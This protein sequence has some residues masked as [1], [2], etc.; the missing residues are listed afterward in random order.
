MRIGINAIFR[1]KPTGVANYICNLVYNLSR[2]DREN[3]YYIFIN[4]A[5]RRYFP[6]E[7]ENFMLISCNMYSEMPAYRRLW[8]Q[9]AFPGY[10]KKYGLDL[11]HCP[12][13]VLPIMAKCK[14]VLTLIDTQYFQN[15]DHFSFLRRE[16]L[17]T[18]MKMSFEKS[19]GVITI[20]EEVKKEIHDIFDKSR[21][22]VK[23]IHLGMSDSFRVIENEK[24]LDVKKKYGIRGPYILFF[25]YPHYRKNLLRL[26]TAFSRIIKRLPHDY[27]FVIAG[28][29]GTEET[30][31]HKV[32]EEIMNH[33]LDK[34][35]VFTGYIHGSGTPGEYEN[36]DMTS[37]LNG[38][39]L[40]VYPSLYEGFGLPVVEAMACGTPVLTSDIPVMHEL[41]GDSAVIVDPKDIDDI[42]EGMLRGLTDKALRADLVSEG[43]K[44]AEKYSWENTAKKTLDYYKQIYRGHKS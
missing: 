8:E 22:K 11:L 3:E 17:K 1:F 2:I 43:L 19:D 12:I 24:V 23:A 21:G 18:M 36:L 6:I 25:G 15:P 20:S 44:L 10:V 28:E 13:N 32:K 26:I 42:A 29:M 9:F 40:M 33:G 30:D 14:T 16:Y 39:E 38:A 4:E 35:V 27:L 41:V 5:N 7:Q 31:F 37:I 34:R